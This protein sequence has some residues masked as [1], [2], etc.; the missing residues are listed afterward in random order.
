MKECDMKKTQPEIEQYCVMSFKEYDEIESCKDSAN[1][2]H[3]CCDHEFGAL[4]V[5][6]RD[7]CYNNMCGGPR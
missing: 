3:D 5:A 2:C 1:F 6:Q 7:N 4:K